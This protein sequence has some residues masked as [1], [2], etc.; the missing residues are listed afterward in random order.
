MKK[1]TGKKENPIMKNDQ[2]INEHEE[3]NKMIDDFINSKSGN[4]EL[5]KS[6]EEMFND[7]IETL[8]DLA[9][10]EVKQFLSIKKKKEK[11]Q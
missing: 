8:D 5:V 4:A 1:K 11:K 10:L 6:P 7:Y 3:I 9:A 2:I